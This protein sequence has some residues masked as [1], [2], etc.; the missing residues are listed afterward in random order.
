[1]STLAR[2]DHADAF[3]LD[4]IEARRHP[5]R[6]WARLVFEQAPLATRHGLQRGWVA[7]GLRLDD[8]VD[9]SVLGWQQRHRT[10]DFLLLGAGS[11]IGMPAEL[12]LQRAES[13]LLLAT[14]VEFQ[15]P[16]ARATWAAVEPLHLKVVP[17]VLARAGAV[18]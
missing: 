11:R 9:R 8:G 2:V 1:M 14:L 16:L 18:E 6:E 13:S 5:P 10:L 7:L 15:N 4:G 3:E 12:L 17:R